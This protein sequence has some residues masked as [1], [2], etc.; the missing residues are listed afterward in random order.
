MNDRQSADDSLVRYLLG[1][2][3]PDDEQAEIEERYFT[4][5]LYFDRVL[6]IEDDL[7]DSH[8]RGS[9]SDIERDRFEKHFLA[10]DRRREKWEAQWAIASF[11]RCRSK[12]AGLVNGSIR[13][14]GS[15]AFGARLLLGISVVV[16]AVGISILGSRYVEIRNES[17]ALQSRLVALRE[18][19]A[20]RVAIAMFVLEPERL[21]SGPGAELRIAKDTR[22]VVLKVELPQFAAAHSIFAARLNTADGQAIWEQSHLPR[23]ASTVEI[24]LPASAL[25][26][27]DFVLSL[28][29][30][31]R[32]RQIKLPAYQ[33]RID[34]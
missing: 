29:A 32:E 22:W 15:L 3:L 33:F 34:R 1:E 27:G 7:I 31:D 24:N 30:L 5:E 16:V 9:L 14:W 11:F 28:S 23:V 19:S 25:E 8:I 2:A 12:P 6:A 10:S 21:R 13:F 4:D 18:Q 26:R 20:T 17:N